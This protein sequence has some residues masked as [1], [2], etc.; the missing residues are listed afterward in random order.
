MERDK[1]HNQ[2]KPQDSLRTITRNSGSE[3]Y[4]HMCRP[5]RL[6]LFIGV[7]EVYV[8]FVLGRETAS[9]PTFPMRMTAGAYRGSWAVSNSGEVGQ[10][11][12]RPF[13]C[14]HAWRDIL[15]WGSFSFTQFL[16]SDFLPFCSFTNSCD[17]AT[18]SLV[19]SGSWSSES[20][21]PLV[22]NS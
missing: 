4:C 8:S 12:K 10:E 7:Q 11:R 5:W 20:L 16:I 2:T 18:F 19:F 9:C 14:D 21:T 22:S 1:N 17:T 15:T 13:L 6:I 3:L